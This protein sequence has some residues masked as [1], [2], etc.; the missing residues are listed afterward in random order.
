LPK[1]AAVLDGLVALRFELE[2]RVD[3][4]LFA[5]RLAVRLRPAG[6]AWVALLFES[7]MTLRPTEFKDPTVVA[8][9]RDTVTGVDGRGAKE[10]LFQSHFSRSCIYLCKLIKKFNLKYLLFILAA[11]LF[12]LFYLKYVHSIVCTCMVYEIRKKNENKE[13]QF[14]V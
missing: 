11:E 3:G 6:L 13:L 4:E 2:D 8:H 5:R 12:F 9:E 14:S 7:A 10:A 1:L